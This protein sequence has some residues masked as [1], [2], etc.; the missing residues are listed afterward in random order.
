MHAKVRYNPSVSIFAK[1]TLLNTENAPPTP[2]RRIDRPWRG[3]SIDLLARDVVRHLGW[4]YYIGRIV[5]SENNASSSSCSFSE[6]VDCHTLSERLK[7]W[8]TATHRYLSLSATR[9]WKSEKHETET[10]RRRLF[11]AAEEEDSDT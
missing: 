6:R 3:I 8:P 9:N 7:I 2:S 4:C 5:D 10:T 1:T 11:L